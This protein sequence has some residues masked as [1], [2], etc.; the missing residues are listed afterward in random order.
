MKPLF[1]VGL[2]FSTGVF[3]SA[4]SQDAPPAAT[5][6]ASASPASGSLADLAQHR[7]SWPAQLTLK[8]SVRLS[9]ISNG[10]EVGAIE[11][12]EGSTVN[13]VA[14]TAT[15]LE[16]Q[17]V[18]AR[19]SVS[20]EQT[21]LW[22]RIAAA[23]G[24]TNPVAA[25]PLAVP[26]PTP[27]PPAP[28]VAPHPAPTAPVVAA[29][30][31]SGPPLHLD[32][33]VSPRDNFTEAAFRFWSPPY[34]Q[35]IRG[36]IVLVPGL[37]GDGRA[38]LDS[39][40]WQSLA[41]KYRLALVSCFLKGGNY[42]NAPRGTGDALLEALKNFSQD[43]NHPEIAQA[44]ILLYG[45]SAGGQF[46]YDFVLWKPD[47]VMAFVVNKGGYYDGG[48]ADSH[49]RAIPGLFFLGL[50]DSDLRID[51]ITRIWTAG[52]KAGALWALA[53]QPNSGHEF[54]KTAAIAQVFFDSVLKFRLPDE[55]LADGD[56]PAMKPMQ[57][58]QGW[59]GD[60]T[61]YEIHDGSTDTEPDRAAAWLPDQNSANAWKKF[62]SH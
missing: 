29:N 49:V 39:P 11:S 9:I 52:R 34:T 19:A 26:P 24:K 42:Y 47:R 58:N 45:E 30:T 20:P 21:D 41:R 36:I 46:D 35:P 57:E 2:F 61:S 32:Y 12:P 5:N 22:E 17:V 44:P 40:S 33:E 31:A 16:V 1:L 55:S 62:V 59:L 60:L 38:M 28:P 7:S 18:S 15:G 10:K 54:S 8:V 37:N 56:A 27:V 14:V 23:S 4:F 6:Q 53:P 51:A 13:L 25:A 43:A 50:K 48:E 3:L